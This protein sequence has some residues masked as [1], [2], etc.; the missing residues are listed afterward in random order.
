MNA[1]ADDTLLCYDQNGTVGGI[2][3][4]FAAAAVEDGVVLAGSTNREWSGVDSAFGEEDFA[5]V[6]LNTD[7]DE[8]WRWQVSPTIP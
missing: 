1:V 2:S 6:K 7:G 4:I 5:A 3:K 8:V